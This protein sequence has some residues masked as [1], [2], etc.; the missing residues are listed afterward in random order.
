MSSTS[1]WDRSTKF[2]WLPLLAL[3]ALLI[4]GCESPQR[5]VDSLRAQITSYKAAPDDKKQADIEKSL[6][7]LETQVNE[8]E[9]KNDDQAGYYKEEL[10]T[11]RGDYRDAKLAKA[12]QDAKNAIQGLGE[13]V[14]DGAKNIGDLFKSSGTK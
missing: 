6:A 11:L 5:T 7:K 9:K 12:V 8:L 4:T 1:L 13:A 10:L 2:F 3:T 14:K